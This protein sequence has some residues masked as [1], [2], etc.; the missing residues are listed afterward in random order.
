MRPHVFGIAGWPGV[1]KTALI[2]RLVPELQARG[3]RV[4]ALREAT[5]PARTTLYKA[6]L[7]RYEQAGITA[8]ALVSPPSGHHFD[9]TAVPRPQEWLELLPDVD[10]VL[11]EGFRSAPWPKL[12]VY[13]RRG[14][15]WSSGDP[16]LVAVVGMDRPASITL[17]WFRPDE[18]K[19]IVDAIENTRALGLVNP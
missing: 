16:W 14:P 11:A 7:W 1:G 13:G 8:V 5:E 15:L 19:R 17:P 2:E 18:P 6:D 10:L 4:G 9:G 12:E 3:F